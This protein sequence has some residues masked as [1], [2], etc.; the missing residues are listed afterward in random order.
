MFLDEC[1]RWASLGSHHPFIMHWMLTHTEAT[2]QKEHD[3]A[4]C[5]GWWQPSPKWDLVAE[6]SAMDIIG[7]GTF[8]DE[9]RVIYN[10]VYQLQRLPSR[11]PCDGEAEEQVCQEIQ[12]SIKECLQCRWDL[13]RGRTEVDFS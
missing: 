6:S 11:S 13:A 8:Q 12:E 1:P 2:G 4:I 5:Q 10:E 3:Q 9:I 7:A